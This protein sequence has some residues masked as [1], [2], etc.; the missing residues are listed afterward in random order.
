M[1]AIERALDAIEDLPQRDLPT[2]LDMMQ[3]RLRTAYGYGKLDPLSP[4]W[5]MQ[6]KLWPHGA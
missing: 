2:V 1:T 4:G 5:E 3:T 6:A